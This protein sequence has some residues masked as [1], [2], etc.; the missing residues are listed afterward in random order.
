MVIFHNGLELIRVEF[1]YEEMK[2]SP[3]ISRN[4]PPVAGNISWSRHMLRKIEEPLRKFQGNSSVLA[5]KES[6]K[7]I[8]T[9][10]KV[11]RTLIAFE[12]LWYEACRS[13]IEQ[14]KACKQLS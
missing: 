9:Y 8:R 5:P 3:P 14:A 12:Y 11:A 4:M 2:H 6:K 7:I 13:S 10:N 1:L